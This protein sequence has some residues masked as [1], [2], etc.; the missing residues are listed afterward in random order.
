[1][2]AVRPVMKSTIPLPSS[3]RVLLFLDYSTLY[4]S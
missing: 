1:M 4:L 3:D 2:L